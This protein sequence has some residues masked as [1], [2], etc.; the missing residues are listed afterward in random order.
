MKTRKPGPA[1]VALIVGATDFQYSN[2][3]VQGVLDSA[4]AGEVSLLCYVMLFNNVKQQFRSETLKI[5]DGQVFDALLISGSLHNE[6]SE[7]E[8]IAF[9]ERFPSTPIITLGIKIPGYRG[10]L[11]DN[12]SGMRALMEHL[13][14]YHGYARIAFIG[15]PPGHLEAEQRKAVFLEEMRK[16]NLEIRDEWIT[17]GNY[18]PS[19]GELAMAGLLSRGKPEFQGVVV[20]NDGMAFAAVHHLQFHGYSVPGDLFVTGFDDFYKSFMTTVRQSAYE[21]AK[22]ATRDLLAL[23]DGKDLPDVNV[24]PSS[25]II[26]SSCGCT[27]MERRR[28]SFASGTA[29]FQGR[30][31][32]LDAIADS[33]ENAL[34]SGSDAVFLDCLDSLCEQNQTV[35]AG[36]IWQTVT[37]RLRKLDCAA[38][39]QGEAADRVRRLLDSAT[40]QLFDY[41]SNKPSTSFFSMHQIALVK[42]FTALLMT[43]LVM[44]PVDQACFCD[45]STRKDS[46]AARRHTLQAGAAV[47]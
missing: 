45:G 4:A 33:F 3:L 5:I 25:L 7:S 15:G 6:I 11:T 18:Q 26:R 40:L 17:Y 19:A 41:V 43:T 31:L 47:S 37:G 44:E 36:T 28:L 35:D 12:T 20:A 30:S 16:R 24:V 22:N 23:L 21:Q 39:A 32:G 14:D 1:T 2:D 8:L 46:S 27:P 42:D 13:L 38:R 29:V 10:L 34:E 9:C